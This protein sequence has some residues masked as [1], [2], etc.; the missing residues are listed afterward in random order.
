MDKTAVEKIDRIIQDME[1][2]QRKGRLSLIDFTRAAVIISNMKKIK[3]SYVSFVQ[4]GNE[5]FL[6]QMEPLILEALEYSEEMLKSEILSQTCNQ[7]PI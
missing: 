7:K 3:K 5:E 1:F 2:L 4:T 6:S